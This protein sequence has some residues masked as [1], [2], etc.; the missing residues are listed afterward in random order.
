MRG[1]QLMSWPSSRGL[2]LSTLYDGGRAAMLSEETHSTLS[3]GGC[4]SQASLQTEV[5]SL[6]LSR[7]IT[8]NHR[9]EYKRQ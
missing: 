8:L 6:V 4:A 2:G 3:T 1:T 9:G 7:R 5:S